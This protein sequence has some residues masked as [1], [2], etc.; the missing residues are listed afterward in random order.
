[1]VRT[2]CDKITQDGAPWSLVL[3]VSLSLTKCTCTESK[4]QF[5]SIF[6]FKVN[7]Q[8]I[9]KKANQSK[10][11]PTLREGE[12]I[13]YV[14]DI[15]QGYTPRQGWSPV[16]NTRVKLNWPTLPEYFFTVVFPS[17]LFLFSTAMQLSNGTFSWR[18]YDTIELW[19]QCTILY[20]MHKCNEHVMQS[21]QLSL[22]QAEYY[23]HSDTANIKVNS[24]SFL[25]CGHWWYLTWL[26]CTVAFETDEISI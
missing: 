6:Y 11:N 4:K 24:L 2:A 12:V 21:Q 1:M 19:G 5:S 9:H 18:K 26:C 22:C 25:N 8:K 7:K 16:F 3:N 13:G 10:R 14:R 15:P 20:A 17:F 23:V